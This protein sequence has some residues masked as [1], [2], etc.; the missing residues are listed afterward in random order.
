MLLPMQIV[1][2]RLL[3]LLMCLHQAERLLILMILVVD[4]LPLALLLILLLVH[5]L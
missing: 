1:M 4:Q 3:V 2:V 5:I